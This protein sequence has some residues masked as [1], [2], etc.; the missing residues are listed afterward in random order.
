MDDDVG[1]GY[2][3]SLPAFDL[4]NWIFYLFLTL[5]LSIWMAF[6]PY[7][8]LNDPSMA[9]LL[10]GRLENYRFLYL[11]A[12]W[13]RGWKFHRLAKDNLG[14]YL[15]LNIIN[16]LPFGLIGM[17]AVG[18]ML[19]VVALFQEFVIDWLLADILGY[20]VSY[21]WR[22]ATVLGLAYLWMSQTAYKRAQAE[23]ALEEVMNWHEK[24][25]NLLRK[26]RA[27]LD[28]YHQLIED[29]SRSD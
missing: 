16:L 20:S 18:G 8:D 10:K 4:G 22:S 12:A 5:A 26:D 3:F 23:R 2:L 9:S 6:R 27:S 29:A 17:F 19:I 15:V 7:I 25:Y 21:D 11:K 28:E 14:S 1:F 24:A 13:G